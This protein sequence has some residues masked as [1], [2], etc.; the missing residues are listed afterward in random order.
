VNILSTLEIRGN[1]RGYILTIAHV[2]GS[3][4]PYYFSTDDMDVIRKGLELRRV[5]VDNTFSIDD[6]RVSPGRLCA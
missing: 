2:A 5:T 1:S 6:R 3:T 4:K